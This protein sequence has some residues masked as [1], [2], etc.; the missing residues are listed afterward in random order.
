MNIEDVIKFVQS[1]RVATDFFDDLAAREKNYRQTTVDRAQAITKASRADVISMFRSM[2]DHGLGKFVT[3]RRGAQSRFEWSVSM[4]DAGLAVTGRGGQ[5]LAALDE[6]EYDIADED[7]GDEF[8]NHEF[9][10]RDGANG[11]IIIALPNDLTVAEARRL[12][13]FISS[14]PIVDEEDSEALR[15]TAS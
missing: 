8:I 5:T 12:G 10:L 9:R 15:A 13:V 2:E 4:V 3:G 11:T 14:L 6:S 1:D 7:D